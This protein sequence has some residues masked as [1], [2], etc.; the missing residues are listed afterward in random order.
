MSTGRY[1]CTFLLKAY[2]DTYE[3]DENITG[4]TGYNMG[5]QSGNSEKLD[6]MLLHF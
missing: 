3:T 2:P 4:S 6:D 1:S 5:R